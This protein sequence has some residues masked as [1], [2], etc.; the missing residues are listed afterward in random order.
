MTFKKVLIISLL[1]LKPINSGM[2]NTIF[3]LHKFL[4][5]KNKVD[6]LEIK[7]KS[8]IDPILN[9]KFN[10]KSSEKI[11]NKIN[12]F[13]PDLVFINTSKLLYLYKDLLLGSNRSFKAILVCHDLYYFRKKYFFQ[14]NKKDK[15]P[16]N[17][18]KEIHYIKK[19][20][21]IMD[22]SHLEKNYLIKKK[23]S[24]KKMIDTQTPTFLFKKKIKKRKKYD[25]VFI[26]SNWFQNKISVKWILSNIMKK[27]PNLSL[28]VVGAKINSLKNNNKNILFKKYKIEN[29][30]LAKIGLAIIK[31]GTGRKVK[32]FEMLA[33][34][35]PIITNINLKNFGLKN[36]KHYIFAKT[37]FQINENIRKLIV[38]SKLRKKI[39]LNAT[40]WAIKY[41][42]Y[43]M[44]YKKLNFLFK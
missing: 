44:V 29:I 32:I 1:P 8:L 9:L 20:D 23:V 10:K 7:T 15:T 43:L 18:N 27:L 16:L 19:T 36:R 39:S 6:F 22:F 14:I 25:L 17:Q 5:K 42:N 31:G 3:L 34:G 30:T 33:L 11:N 35:L 4:K 41:S 24:R 13:Q 26:G 38:D 21:Y 12:N 2:Q 37:K 40:R 28:L